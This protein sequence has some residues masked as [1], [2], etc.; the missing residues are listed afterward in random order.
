MARLRQFDVYMSMSTRSTEECEKLAAWLEEAICDSQAEREGMGE[1]AALRAAHERLR[2]AC[3]VRRSDGIHLYD[4][5]FVCN[6]FA[7]KGNLIHKPTCPV[8][9]GA[10][11]GHE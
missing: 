11:T 1:A 10:G 5:C 3:G 2:E 6:A 8:A 7:A 4:E 9:P